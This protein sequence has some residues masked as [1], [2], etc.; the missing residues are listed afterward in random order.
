MRLIQRFDSKARLP[1][2][3][4]QISAYPR[5]LYRYCGPS[6]TTIKDLTEPHTN[7][8]IQPTVVREALFQPEFANTGSRADNVKTAYKRSMAKDLY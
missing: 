5:P 4:K 6:H 2:L 3:L 7:A 8:I 1:E